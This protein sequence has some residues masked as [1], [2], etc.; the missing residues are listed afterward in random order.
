VSV[1]RHGGTV[2]LASRDADATVR[3]LVTTG[4]AFRDLE[5]VGADLDAAFLA[6]TSRAVAPAAAGR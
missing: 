6:L 2:V 3:S 4:V 1:D 5:L